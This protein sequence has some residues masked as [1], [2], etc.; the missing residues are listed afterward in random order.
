MFQ[1][2]SLE[3]GRSLPLNE[4]GEVCMKGPL[5]MKGYAGNA[6]ETRNAIDDQAWF[7]SGKIQHE[8]HFFHNRILWP[9]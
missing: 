8:L 4:R 1:I 9:S 5:I 6:E 2:I 3:D 7:H